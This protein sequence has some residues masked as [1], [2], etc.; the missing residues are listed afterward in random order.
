MSLQYY[1]HEDL[2][3]KPP[4]GSGVHSEGLEPGAGDYFAITV[5]NLTLAMPLV[6]FALNGGAVGTLV[7]LGLIAGFNGLVL[8]G[9]TSSRRDPPA[10]AA[11]AR[12]SRR[13]RASYREG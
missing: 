11:T 13:V 8:R 7:V 2:H 4:V 3:V 12:V 6:S 10:A 9:M 5:I 1:P